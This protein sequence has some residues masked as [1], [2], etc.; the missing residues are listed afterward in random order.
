MILT[1]IRSNMQDLAQVLLRRVD[2][3]LILAGQTLFP[4][5]GFKPGELRLFLIVSTLCTKK[6]ANLFARSTALSFFRCQAVK[7]FVNGTKQDR[8]ILVLVFFYDRGVEGHLGLINKVIDQIALVYVKLSA[9]IGPELA[10]LAFKSS[11]FCFF[12]LSLLCAPWRSWSF[13]PLSPNS[14]QHQFSPCNVY[15]SQ[16]ILVTRIKGLITQ[17]EFS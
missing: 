12:S 17:D 10:P 14:D 5:L 2:S 8:L 1:G 16:N 15:A 11:S 13:N 4:S 6:S 3:Q 9:D 7:H